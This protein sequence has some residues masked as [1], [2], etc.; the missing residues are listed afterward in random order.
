[1]KQYI[2]AAAL[3]CSLTLSAEEVVEARKREYASIQKELEAA[4]P[5]TDPTREEV[6]A[7]I[8]LAMEKFGKFSK[9]NPKTAEGFEAGSTLASLLAQVRHQD[10]L[11]F[12]ELA[13]NSAPDAGV[14]VK[15][16]AMCWALVADGKLQKSDAAGAEAA[17][18]K[19]KP[20][21]PQ[22]Y[23]QLIK[24]FSQ[25]KQ[26]MSEQR[27]SA[28]R[29]QVGK[30]P[31]A[32]VDTDF[33][34]NPFSLAGL[35]GKVVIIDF[36]APWCGPCMQEMPALIELYKKE[37][38]NGLEIVGISLDKG[39]ESLKSTITET[40]ITWPVLSDHKGW[41]SAIAKKWGIRSIPATY[42]LDRKGLI[43]HTS[44]RGE[45]LADAVAKL[46]QEK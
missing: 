17:L 30:E 8:E 18:E 35:K 42:I 25:A 37:K 31:F 14:D 19:V 1:M 46:L 12:A 2:C 28:E 4:R 16:V 39:E 24:Q 33:S 13:A 27:E 22:I 20:L 23:E 7:Y 9:D 6:M 5:A 44:L 41:Q 15:R 29:L 38:K 21:D 36:W 40:G 45:E 3:L 32:I 34:G 26:Q 43:R 10:A 11:K